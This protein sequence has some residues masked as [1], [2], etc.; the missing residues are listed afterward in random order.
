MMAIVACA[1][2]PSLTVAPTAATADVTLVIPDGT[3]AAFE[4]GDMTAFQFPEQI[5]LQTGQAVVITNHDHA[6]HYFF[7]VPIAP[8]QTIRKTFE[9]TGT[10]VYQGGLSCSMGQSSNAIWVRVD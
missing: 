1:T 9:R 7:D 4:R 6:M 5:R 10:F 2:S 3:E 8:G